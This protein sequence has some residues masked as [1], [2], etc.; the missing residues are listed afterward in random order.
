MEGVTAFPQG[1]G[2]C[3]R[4]RTQFLSDDRL[5]PM[6]DINQDVVDLEGTLIRY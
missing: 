3:I 1:S 4:E 2:A 6:V 5:Q